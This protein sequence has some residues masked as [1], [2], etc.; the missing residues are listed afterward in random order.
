MEKIKLSDG[1]ELPKGTHFAVASGPVLLDADNVP[2]P[3]KFD[4]LRFYRKRQAPGEA[5]KHLL[6][7]TDKDHLHFGHGKYACP[8]RF[9]A[10]NEM[11]MILARF[12]LEYEF[13]YPEGHGRPRNLTMDEN[14]LPDP[15]ATLLVRKHKVVN[16]KVPTMNGRVKVVEKV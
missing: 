3:D 1:V 5:N 7:M 2:N 6:P 11:K 12:L 9:F 14:V 4:P 16:E 13:K 15:A 8:G 10:A